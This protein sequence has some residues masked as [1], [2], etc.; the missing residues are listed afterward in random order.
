MF[1]QLNSFQQKALLMLALF[2]GITITQSVAQKS[3]GFKAGISLNSYKPTGN[4]NEDYDGGSTIG[5]SGELFFNVPLGS[6]GLSVV[7]GAGFT[8][9]HGGKFTSEATA[10]NQTSF[11]IARVVVENGTDE[12]NSIQ[13]SSLLRYTFQGKSISPYFETGPL[14][15]FNLSG[16]NVQEGRILSVES[17]SGNF[18]YAP[19]RPETK[20][21]EFGNSTSDFY[22][23]S[24][25]VWA[26]GAGLTADFEFGTLSFGVRYNAANIRGKESTRGPA[27]LNMTYLLADGSVGQLEYASD[28]KLKLRT[29]A[30]QIG[31][32][33]SIGGY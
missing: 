27:G 26:F 15:N 6:S 12:F 16:E 11:P 18:I 31:Y 29:L 13:L 8:Y 14:V 4:I 25:F 23:P 10:T 5:Y 2:I 3:A 22:K 19:V 9:G 28:D 24:T 33:I 1:I 30:V 32:S 20:E 21:L 7:P 17:S